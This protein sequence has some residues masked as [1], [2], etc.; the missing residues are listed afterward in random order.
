MDQNIVAADELE[1][2]RQATLFEAVR[3]TRP[4]WFTARTAG[5]ILVY[6]DDQ[7]VGGVGVLRNMSV[8]SAAR[9]IYLSPNEAQLRFGPRNG[10]RPAI[11]VESVR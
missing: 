9:V 3:I 1:A 4:L 7:P 8:L 5:P 6:Q 2:T 11:L 10:M